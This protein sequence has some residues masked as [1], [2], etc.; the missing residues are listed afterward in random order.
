MK[1]D[2][3]KRKR[4]Y[5]KYLGKNSIHYKYAVYEKNKLITEFLSSEKLNLKNKAMRRTV[6]EEIADIIEECKIDGI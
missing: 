3:V 5:I 4:Y 6:I 2:Y 1:G